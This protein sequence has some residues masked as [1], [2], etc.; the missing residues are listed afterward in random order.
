MKKTGCR[1]IILLSERA[2]HHMVPSKETLIKWLREM[3][4]Q[5]MS[6]ETTDHACAQH[7]DIIWQRKKH[8]LKAAT[9][10]ASVG[11]SKKKSHEYSH[12]ITIA[13]MARLMLTAL[14]IKT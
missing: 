14:S 2:Q 6:N 8:G 9:K 5:R 1:K 10:N 11:R 3:P 12:V 13:P 7:A 4:G